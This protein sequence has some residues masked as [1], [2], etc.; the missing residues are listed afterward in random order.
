MIPRRHAQCPITGVPARTTEHFGTNNVLWVLVDVLPHLTCRQ[1]ILLPSMA[2]LL[3]TSGVCSHENCSRS[4]KSRPT[5]LY[6]SY[7]QRLFM[8]EASRVT[9]VPVGSH[10]DWQPSGGGTLHVPPTVKTISR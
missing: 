6:R 3:M 2:K 1:Q 4:P 7:Q 10:V 8:R 5:K 9:L